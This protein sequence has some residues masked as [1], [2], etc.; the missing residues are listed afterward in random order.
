[1]RRLA[2]ALKGGWHFSALDQL[3]LTFLGEYLSNQKGRLAYASPAKP[4]ATK[5]LSAPSARL[6]QVDHGAVIAHAFANKFSA[7]YLP[8]LRLAAE[9]TE[10]IARAQKTKSEAERRE[11]AMQFTDELAVKSPPAPWRFIDDVITSGATAEA[12]W[13]A[14]GKPADFEV[15]TLICRPKLAGR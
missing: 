8:F 6:C 13:L 2:Y 10:G 7:S 15:W 14:I 5:I 3:I 4:Q 12:A 11:R 9:P 1:M